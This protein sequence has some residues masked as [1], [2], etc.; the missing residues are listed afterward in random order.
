L[1]I[2]GFKST[3]STPQK[4]LFEKISGLGRSFWNS[5]HR[6]VISKVFP[7]TRNFSFSV[8]V[9][10]FLKHRISPRV[11]WEVVRWKGYDAG[12]CRIHF[13]YVFCCCWISSIQKIQYLESVYFGWRSSFFEVVFRF[14]KFMN[15]WFSTSKSPKTSIY[16]KKAKNL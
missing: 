12:S 16:W 14:F 6:F 15:F 9:R 3:I 11:G 7:I 10:G 4:H 13:N 8:V 5:V 2:L 1:S